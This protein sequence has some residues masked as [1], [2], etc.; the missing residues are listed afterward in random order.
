MFRIPVLGEFLNSFEHYPGVAFLLVFAE[1]GVQRFAG[2]G[3]FWRWFLYA[4][5]TACCCVF[6]PLY[7]LG[8]G[9]QN[10]QKDGHLALSVR[11]EGSCVFWVI[12]MVSH[13][14]QRVFATLPAS[15]MISL[16]PGGFVCARRSTRVPAVGTIV[17]FCLL[18]AVC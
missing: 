18:L 7:G 15:V 5:F 17:S 1:L 12:I 6:I 8:W 9:L 2:A 14:S 11:F 3:L 10:S 13:A 16:C 4:L